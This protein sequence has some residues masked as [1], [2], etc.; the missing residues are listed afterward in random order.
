MYFRPQEKL[1]IQDG[2]LDY[3]MLYVS[4]IQIYRAWET[5]DVLEMIAVGKNALACIYHNILYTFLNH[6][7][8]T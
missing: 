5:G 6:F 8:D 3:E 1:Y 7:M 4:I 2:I